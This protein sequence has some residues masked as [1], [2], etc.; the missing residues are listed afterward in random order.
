MEPPG[1]VPTSELTCCYDLH[2]YKGILRR[3]KD[4]KMQPVL[5]SR[6]HS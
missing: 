2:M 5:E 1:V 4:K 3:S 6:L